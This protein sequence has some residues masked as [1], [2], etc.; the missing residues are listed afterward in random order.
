[1]DLVA[2]TTHGR[3]GPARMVMGSVAE[4]MIRHSDVPVLLFRSSGARVI[5]KEEHA[6]PAA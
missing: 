2:M 4:P 6:A 1:M 5:K 3:T